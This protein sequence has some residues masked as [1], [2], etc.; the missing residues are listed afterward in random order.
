M[1]RDES[2]MIV[3]FVF[4]VQVTA[5]KML[6]YFVRQ[7]C[8]YFIYQVCF[9][10]Y[11]PSLFVYSSPGLLLECLHT[12]TDETATYVVAREQVAASLKLAVNCLV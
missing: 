2:I 10:F 5:S 6:I 8:F 9:L 12:W 11:S 7:V 1:K 4:T 3:G